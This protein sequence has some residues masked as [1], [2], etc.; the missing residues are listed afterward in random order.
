MSMAPASSMPGSSPPRLL[1]TG[2]ECAS[3]QGDGHDR[4]HDRMAPARHRGAVHRRDHDASA[5]GQGARFWDALQGDRVWVWTPDGPKRLS[6]ITELASGL[7]EEMRIERA[8]RGITPA[9]RQMASLDRTVE[10]IIKIAASR[11]SD[12]KAQVLVGCKVF[13]F[14]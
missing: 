10:S 3:E 14:Y 8:T 12:R 6:E 11:Q 4:R 1:K 2:W 13:S 9:L 7:K 5:E